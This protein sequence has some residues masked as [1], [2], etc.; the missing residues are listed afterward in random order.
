MNSSLFDDK[1]FAAPTE[2][3]EADDVFAISDEM[4]QFLDTDFA[5]RVHKDGRIAG[6]LNALYAKGKRKFEYNSATTGNAAQVFHE[7]N[8]NCLSY[9]IMT[10]AFAKKLGLTVEFHTV[11]FGDVWDRNENIEYLIGHV[12][13]TLSVQDTQREPSQLVDIGAFEDANGELLDDISEDIIVGMYLNNRAAEALAKNNLDNAYWWARAAVLRAPAFTPA[14]NTLGV[15]YSRHHNVDQADRVFSAVL[16]REPE[17]L[18]ALSNQIQVLQ[19]LGRTNESVAMAAKL[20]QLQP[21]PPYFYF[22]R[23]IAAMH[24]GDYKTAK[25][26]FIKEVNRASYNPQFHFGLALANYYLGNVEETR[27]Q[28]QLAMENSANAA[29]RDL[30]AAK[31]VKLKSAGMRP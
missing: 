8:G 22:N 11:T 1:Q 7:R 3:I 26:E 6:L 18:L 4:Q 16:R 28:L 20:A 10:A 30:Y 19:A 13:L 12:N 17:N 31:L 14:Y 23:G 5:R 29:Q 27:K 25:A 9:T 24:A 15:I 2:R 21:N